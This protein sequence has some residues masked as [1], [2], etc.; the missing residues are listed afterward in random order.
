MNIL[1]G[2][3]L[4]S[5]KII[6]YTLLLLVFLLFIFCISHPKITIKYKDAPEIS[7]TLWF[8][9]FNI[10]KFL[11]RKK[12]KKR[13]VILHFDGE[14]F[15]EAP[16]TTRKH[17][18]SK[19]VR[20][21]KSLTKNKGSVQAKKADTTLSEKISGILEL[22]EDIFGKIKEPVKKVILV[23]IKSLHLTSASD[24]PHD[25]AMLFGNMNTGVGVIFSLCKQFGG[26]KID[27]NNIGVYSDFCGNKPSFDI[28]IELILSSRHIIHC[29]IGALTGYL[30]NKDNL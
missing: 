26:L 23:N 4:A 10:T 29:A 11:N 30:K 9:R 27:Q 1:F 19:K 2:V 13:P 12:K 8:F 24:N 14:G 6:L 25:T 21:K 15:G 17:I 22:I 18:K 5:L 7:A 28:H 20:K 3:I 16:I